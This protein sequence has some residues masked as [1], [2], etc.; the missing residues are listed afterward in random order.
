MR[1]ETEMEQDW[2][3]GLG[4]HSNRIQRQGCNKDRHGDRDAEE[5][6]NSGRALDRDTSDVDADGVWIRGMK[7]DIEKGW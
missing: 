4:R 6:R 1:T 5:K 7:R 2:H 3:W